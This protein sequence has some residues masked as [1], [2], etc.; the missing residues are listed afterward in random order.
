MRLGWIL[1][2]VVVAVGA[3]G[4]GAA[5]GA[6]SPPGSGYAWAQPGTA[7]VSAPYG[8]PPTWVPFALVAPESPAVSGYA[9]AQP[10]TAVVS[11]PDAQPPAWILGG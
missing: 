9:W 10:H 5:S 7:V 1:S 11:V 2:A 6:A 4:A 8:Q 3:I